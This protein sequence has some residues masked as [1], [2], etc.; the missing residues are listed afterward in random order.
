MRITRFEDKDDEGGFPDEGRIGAPAIPTVRELKFSLNSCP[1]KK[2]KTS[3]NG[4]SDLTGTLIKAALE[5]GVP[6]LFKFTGKVINS[7][8]EKLKRNDPRWV[9]IQIH[10]LAQRHGGELTLSQ[11]VTELS[12]SGDMAKR[13]LKFLIGKKYCLVKHI[14]GTKTRLFVFPGLK[15]K[16]VMK[17][18]E[19]CGSSFKAADIGERC[20]NCQGTMKSVTTI[21]P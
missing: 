8:G 13:V 19:Y 12:I 2:K 9:M 1:K 5:Y 4:E 15:K 11:I 3:T 7:V 17:V 10:N 6:E 21:A 18:C 20:P 16:W 14:E